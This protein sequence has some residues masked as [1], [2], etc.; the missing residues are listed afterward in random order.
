MKT[1][2]SVSVGLVLVALAQSAFAIECRQDVL[3]CSLRGQDK[4]GAY[5][6]KNASG[7]FLP[8]AEEPFDEPNDHCEVQLSFLNADGYTYNAWVIDDNRTN[9]YIGKLDHFGVIDNQQKFFFSKPGDSFFIDYAGLTMTCS[10][11]Q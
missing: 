2:L 3:Q 11:T 4:H 6:I 7:R 9:L 10:L 8:V 5:V 1:S